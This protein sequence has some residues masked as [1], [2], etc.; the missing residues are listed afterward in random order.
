[1]RAP[2]SSSSGTVKTLTAPRPAL[3]YRF[4]RMANPSRISQTDSALDVLP[5]AVPPSVN[6]SS[7]V[8]PLGAVDADP[9]VI[10]QTRLEMARDALARN[11]PFATDAVTQYLQS[12]VAT[13]EHYA[14]KEPDRG[15]L[16]EKV[17]DVIKQFLPA[18]KDYRTVVTALCAA[19]SVDDPAAPLVT[20]FRDLR[21]EKNR[22][23]QEL[24]CVLWSDG[25]RY[26]LRELFL[27]TAGILVRRE[28]YA[29]LSSLL[30]ANYA[31]AGESEQHFTVFDGY[32]KTL[33]EFRNRRLGARRLSICCDVMRDRIDVTQCTFEQMMQA[34]FLLCLRTL[35]VNP[36]FFVRWYPRTLVYGDHFAVQGFDL[37]DVGRDASKFAP[38]ATILDV[39]NVRELNKRFEQTHTAWGLGRWE[40]GGAPLS[41]RGFMGQRSAAGKR[42]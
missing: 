27:T 38:L 4:Q 25:Y 32:A 21:A 11:K 15:L 24:D 39:A 42:T 40:V 26:I 31:S 29:A 23:T 8:R 33:D 5:S 3:R 2:A 16:D 36:S 10:L 41:F 6:A 17:L 9:S 28:R 37:F 7:H 1:M 35:V 20:F 30:S 13:L 22:L 18:L 34:D 19:T 14:V 12:L